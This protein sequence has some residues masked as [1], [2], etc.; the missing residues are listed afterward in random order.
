MEAVVEGESPPV[1]REDG[2]AAHSEDD[3]H[4][5]EEIWP[6]LLRQRDLS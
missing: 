1:P 3:V 5:L 6:A 2:I 4:K